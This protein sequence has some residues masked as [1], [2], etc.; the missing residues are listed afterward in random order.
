MVNHIFLTMALEEGLD[1]PIIN[2]NDN[3]MMGAIYAYKVLANIDKNST[4]FIQKYNTETVPKPKPEESQITLTYAIMNGL[5]GEAAALTQKA[6]ENTDPMDIV[7]KELI[8]ALDKVGADFESNKIFLPQLIQSANVAQAC[9][10]VIKNHLSK[11]N[12]SPVSKGKII[13]ATVKGDIHDIGKN[14]VKVLLDN[15]GYTVVDLGRDVD[16]QVVVDTAIKQDIKMIGLSAL[17]TTTVQSMK[18]TIEALRQSG[19][20]C[21]IVVGGA[22]LT[23]EY[24]LEIGA[25]YYAKDAKQSADIAKKVL[26]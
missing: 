22:V 21:T 2:P 11:N 25:D 9:F 17:M 5:K 18:R 13:L 24:A 3:D 16:P 10:E 23:E 19:H 15:Y 8:P 4:A 26:G 1:L 12:N 7:N 20:P 6:L 14:I